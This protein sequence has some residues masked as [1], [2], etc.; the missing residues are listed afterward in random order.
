M[1]CCRTCCR[2]GEGGTRGVRGA[3]RTD[4]CTYHKKMTG[5]SNTSRQHY[6][7]ASFHPGPS[8]S[9]ITS[10]PIPTILSPPP[11]APPNNNNPNDSNKS[12]A[13]IVVPYIPNTGEKFKKLCKKKGIHVHFKGTNTLRTALGNPKDKDLKK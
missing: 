13:T 9:G 2:L 12:K 8:T 4:M 11:L 10:S 5:N 1:C 6:N 3:F 7:T